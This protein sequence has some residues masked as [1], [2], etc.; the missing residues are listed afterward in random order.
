MKNLA[1]A[2]ANLD[3]PSRLCNM[4]KIHRCLALLK[5]PSEFCCNAQI[6]QMLT[7]VPQTYIQDMEGGGQTHGPATPIKIT[8][9][10]LKNER[11]ALELS[12]KD[13]VGTLRYLS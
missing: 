2:S 5:V 10:T 9:M 3:E 11:F 7:R 13:T 4:L 1:E 8:L 12:S 6:V